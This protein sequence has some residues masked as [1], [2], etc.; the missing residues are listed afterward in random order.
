[1]S[2]LPGHEGCYWV[3]SVHE[4]TQ[5]IQ[6]EIDVDLIHPIFHITQAQGISE[7]LANTLSDNINGVMSAFLQTTSQ[8][9]HPTIS[10]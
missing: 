3:I 9:K 10:T 2:I 7:I 6:S 5:V 1:M 4:N 8:K